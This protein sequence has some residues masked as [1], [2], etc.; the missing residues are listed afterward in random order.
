VDGTLWMFVAIYE[1]YLKFKDEEFLRSVYPFL[2]DILNH[3][4]Q[5]TRYNIRTTEKGF[6]WAGDETTQLTWMDARIG[7]YVV[8]PR[9]GC[10][11]EINALWYNALRIYDFITRRTRLSPFID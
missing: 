2:G 9:F 1:Y 6:L 7:D 5:G 10:P 3:H 8:T 11:V 4:L